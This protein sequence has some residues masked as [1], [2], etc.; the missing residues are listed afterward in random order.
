MDFA[1]PILGFLLVL[2]PALTWLY[3]YGFRRR[4]Q[5]L[6]SFMASG[7]VPDL[8]A[9]AR[10]W[11][12]R[13]KAACLLL[14]AGLLVIALM[15]PRWGLKPE[16]A[17]RF[18]RDIVVILDVSLSMLAAD[19]VPN[20]LERA[21]VMVQGLV[22]QLREDSGHR[23]GLVAFAGRASLQ[24]PLTL[25]YSLFLDRLA[26][27]NPTSARHKGT[28]IGGALRQ[29]PARF[30]NLDPAYTDLILLSDGEDHPGQA[31]DA[32]QDLAQEGFTLYSVA[33]GDDEGA[34][35]IR[36]PGEKGGFVLHRHNGK[37]VQTRTRPALLAELSS[38]TGG[39]L[40]LAVADASPLRIMY[41][42][43]IASKPRRQVAAGTGEFLSDQYHWFVLLALLLIS[44][45]NIIRERVGKRV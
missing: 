8:V 42:D 30:E 26:D 28:D 33:V 34:V 1:V 27:A 31:F 21:K 43:E 23:L 6:H 40:Q 44:L 18:G 32:A 3:R 13:A 14:A 19:V 35:S 36:V 45:E 41:R 12:R 25:D 37:D 22:E 24:S 10:P 5:A 20:R 29:S 17:P 11:R 15:Q 4:R 38:L 7:L 9:Q 16:E 2:M 39:R